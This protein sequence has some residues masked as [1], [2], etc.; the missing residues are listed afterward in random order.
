VIPPRYDMM[1]MIS[2]AFAPPQLLLHRSGA[3]FDFSLLFGFKRCVSAGL[4]KDSL[5]ALRPQAFG[6][7]AC[8]V[9]GKVS[10]FLRR[11]SAKWKL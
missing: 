8:W 9:R 7:L 4:I 6:T 1:M 10:P 3:R 2:P 11:V 5:L